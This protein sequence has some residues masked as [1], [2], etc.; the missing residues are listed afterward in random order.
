[1]VLRGGAGPGSL[2][3]AAA[4]LGEKIFPNLL[5]RTVSGNLQRGIGGA[6]PPFH[7]ET[8]SLRPHGH[9]PPRV[10]SLRPVRPILP[11][12]AGRGRCGNNTM[13]FPMDPVPSIVAREF[14]LILF[15]HPPLFD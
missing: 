14:L 6:A 9:L 13:A 15:D 5:A 4:L 1:M 2:W 11:G 10:F 7:G 12:E 8:P 3:G